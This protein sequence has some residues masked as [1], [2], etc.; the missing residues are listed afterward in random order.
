MAN[1][2]YETCLLFLRYLRVDDYLESD[3]LRTRVQ[4]LSDFSVDFEN[5]VVIES[6]RFDTMPFIVVELRRSVKFDGTLSHIV[7]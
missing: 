6:T 7:L 1:T 3:D 5:T 4:F 2:K